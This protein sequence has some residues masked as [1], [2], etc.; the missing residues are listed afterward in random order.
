MFF[1][2]SC[3][4]KRVI[5]AIGISVI[6]STAL[7]SD[8]FKT[9]LSEAKSGEP[10]AMYSVGV[11][12]L[13]EE[14]SMNEHAFGWVLSAARAGHPQAAELTGKMYRLGL[15]TSRNFV[16]ARKWLYRARARNAVGAYFELA[17]LFNDQD[18]PSYS[19]EDAST[20]LQESLKKHD[21]RACLLAVVHSAR[22]LKPT[23]YALRELICA[24]EGD[25]APAMHL[26]AKYYLSKRSPTATFHAQK[27]LERAEAIGDPLASEKLYEL[28]MR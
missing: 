8:N 2:I 10:Q 19:A 6:C 22:A 14:P 17:L 7:A 4:L 26:L 12:L 27:W 1:N 25:I 21:P 11:M 9:L 13:E 28:S 16:K 20:Y 3:F 15:G 24:A 5:T 23:R 18:N